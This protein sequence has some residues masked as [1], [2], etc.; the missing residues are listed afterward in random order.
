M[1][2]NIYNGII[3]YE[4]S[5]QQYLRTYSPYFTVKEDDIEIYMRRIID[6][7]IGGENLPDIAT[8]DRWDQ[9]IF[10]I[11][12]HYQYDPHPDWLESKQYTVEGEI[13]FKKNGIVHNMYGIKWVCDTSFQRLFWDKKLEPITGPNGWTNINNP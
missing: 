2:R 9:W 5:M 13:R 12:N 10:T 11:W 7:L 6:R 3:F 8:K 4:Y 1:S